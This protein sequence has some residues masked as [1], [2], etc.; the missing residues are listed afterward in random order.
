MPDTPSPLQRFLCLLPWIVAHLAALAISLA[1]L[2]LTALNFSTRAYAIEIL[3]VA[4]L[5]AGALLA[6]MIFNSIEVGAVAMALGFPFALLAARIA[7]TAIG[8]AAVSEAWVAL[9]LL[10]L[11]AWRLSIR[12]E[13]RALLAGI[14]TVY[15]GGWAVLGYVAEEFGS[16]P[17]G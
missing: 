2:P 16:G 1:D 3:V 12:G 4:Q 13:W 9:W 15:V 6:P 14:A 11:G 8:G 10:S 7:G 5:F 17:V